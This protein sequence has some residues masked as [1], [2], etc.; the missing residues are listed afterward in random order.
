[1]IFEIFQAIFS[2]VKIFVLLILKNYKIK[3]LFLIKVNYTK[4]ILN[5]FYHKKVIY[6]VILIIS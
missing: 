6:L 4:D 3:Y 1:M 2:F 5:F